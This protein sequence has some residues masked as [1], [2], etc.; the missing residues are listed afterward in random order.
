MATPPPPYGNGSHAWG[1][2]PVSPYALPPGPYSPQANSFPPPQG[3]ASP[4][5][6]G[7]YAPQ[8]AVPACHICGA[9]PAVP[10]TVRGHQG[11]VVVMRFLSLRGPF[12]RD[13]GLS[14]V[15]DMSAKTL[16]Q[17]WWG[18]LSV[19]IAL[20]T[21]LANLAPW[22]R[23]RKLAAPTGGFR[24]ALAPGRPLTRRPEALVFLVPML[25]V[26]VAIPA[27]FVTGVLVGDG[28]APTLPVGACVRNDGDWA[29]QD[30]QITDCGA[31]GAE[32]KV[33][34]RLEK[35]G[36]TCAGGDYLADPK[37]GPDGATISCLEPLH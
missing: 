12:C 25:L 18:P 27:L 7:P 21:L 37:Y 33:T 10:A 11:I 36:S 28:S 14:T 8:A 30:L 9:L 13:C 32:Y 35:A 31:P 2:Q 20:V 34:R 19:V 23:F 15:R 22:G 29:D 6:P 26:A 24:P 17:G 16:W 5:P 3:A 4:Y 1:S